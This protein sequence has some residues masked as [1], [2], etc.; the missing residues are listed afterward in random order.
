MQAGTPRFQPS[1]RKARATRR[2]PSPRSQGPRRKGDL[3]HPRRFRAALLQGRRD[4]GNPSALH[5]LARAGGRLRRG[6]GGARELR[7]GRRRRHLWRRG[8]QCRERRGGR[9]CGEV[10]RR[11]HFGRARQGGG[12]HGIAAAPPGEDAGFAVPDLPRNHLRP[13]PAR[14]RAPRAG[15]DRAR[16]APLPR[17]IASR[18]HRDAAR[19]GERDLR[20]R[21]AGARGPRGRRRARGVR[22]RDPRAHRRRT[23]AGADGRRRGAPLRSRGEGRGAGREAAPAGGHEHDGPGPPLRHRRAADRHLSRRRRHRRHHGTGRT[24]GRA[25]PAR[26]HHLGHQF[27]RFGAPDR[28]AAHDPRV[29]R[30][31]DARL[32]HLCGH[33]A[34]GAGGCTARARADRVG[35]AGCPRAGLSAASA[36]RR[37]GESRRTTSRAPSTT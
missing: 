1:S 13:G 36:R 25:L 20:C 9:V 28:P 33:S 29:R 32:P 7:A 4:V 30:R 14:R 16:A 6:C 35:A 12:G 18:L 23:V 27:R 21:D 2:I 26:R 15:R 22:G 3:R 19:H 24:V 5:A 11:R 37:C 17:R 10:A 31:G 8:A 34:F